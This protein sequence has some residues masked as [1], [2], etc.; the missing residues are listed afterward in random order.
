M[1][2]PDMFPLFAVEEGRVG[3]FVEKLVT[4]TYG[5]G[6]RIENHA[7]CTMNC[8]RHHCDHSSFK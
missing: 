7:L 2:F 4:L 8:N 5:N 3:M 1:L 6:Q